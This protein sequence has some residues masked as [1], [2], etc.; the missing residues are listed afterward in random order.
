MGPPAGQTDEGP[1]DQQPEREQARA[2]GSE[3]DHRKAHAGDRGLHGMHVV[4]PAH[5]A[6]VIA[7]GRTVSEG[8]NQAERDD[9]ADGREDVAPGRQV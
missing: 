7:R 5:R 2:C 3:S 6:H 9:R 1:A 8:H 4:H